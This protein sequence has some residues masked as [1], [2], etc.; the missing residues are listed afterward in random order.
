VRAILALT[1]AAALAFA[2]RPARADPAEDGPSYAIFALIVGVNASVDPG[3]PVLRYADDDAAR[4]LELFRSLGARAYVLTRLDEDTQRLHPQ[5]AAEALLPV[6]GDFERAVASL[7]RDVRQARERRVKTLL[8]FVYAGHG[9]VKEGRGYIT[10]EDAQ[11]DA[12]ALD[13][14]VVDAIDADQTHF[15]VDACDSYFLALGRGPGGQRHE[16]HGFAGWQ[17]LRVRDS[18]GLLLSTSSARESHEWSGFQA[19]VFSHEVRSALYG[20]ADADGDGQVSYREASAFIERANQAIPNERYRPNVYARSPRDSPVLLDLRAKWRSRIDVP[21]A[22]TGHYLLE[23]SRGIRLAD[24]HNDA[25]P[26]YVIRPPHSGRL[27]M[28]RLDDDVEFVVPGEPEEVALAELEP[29]EPRDHARGAAGDAYQLLFSLPFGPGVVRAY[30][31]R[32]S[33]LDD[34][35]EGDARAPWKTYAGLGLLGLSAGGVVVGALSLESAGSLHEQAL[36]Q[37]NGQDAAALRDRVR[38]RNV[39]ATVAFAAA[40]VAATCGAV[41]IL[42]PSSPSRTQLGVAS[43]AGGAWMSLGGQFP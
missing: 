5:L 25:A 42:W 39:A 35:P 3:T 11:L 20:A 14:R 8:Y 38:D 23:D 18:V 16:A 27:Y 15:I 36:A 13:S 17:G 7:A 34:P 6:R 28:R 26:A 32:R 9:N 24:F 37:A 12:E 31:P 29:A 1:I 4:Y 2:A 10:L 43:T 30:L 22:R 41:L 21:A 33:P 40:G 19:G